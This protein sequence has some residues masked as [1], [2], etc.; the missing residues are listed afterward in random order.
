MKIKWEMIVCGTKSIVDQSPKRE[1]EK[2]PMRVFD[3]VELICGLGFCVSL[4]CI[5]RQ[6]KQSI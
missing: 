6:N 2:L 5:F 3:V 1:R 4:T